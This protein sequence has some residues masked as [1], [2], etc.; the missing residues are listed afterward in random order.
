[1]LAEL[2]DRAA[3]T[4]T[5]VLDAPPGTGKTTRVPLALAGAPWAGGGRIVVLEPRRVAARAAA[6]HMAA[7]LGERPGATVG[8]ITRDDRRAGRSTRVLVVTEG[9]F[10]R[11]VQDDPGLDGVAAVV[12]DEW[13]ERSIHADL[14][15]ALAREVQ[16]ALRPDLRLVVMSATLDGDAARR[17]LGADHASLA[18]AAER[19][20][21]TVAWRARPEPRRFADAVA[22]AVVDGLA[23]QPGD[24]LVFLPGVAEIAA[25]QRALTARRLAAG[26]VVLPLHGRLNAAEQDRALQPAA[27]RRRVVLA[28]D[29]AETSVTVDGVRLVVDG[30]RRRVARF[31]PGRRMD[32]LF[33]VSVSRS[34]AEQR[35]GRAGRQGA[36]HCIRLWPES[37]HHLL[38]DHERPE[39]L[40]ADLCPLAFELA[41]WGAADPS[42]FGWADE[43][44]APAWADAVRTLV[45]LGLA[46]GRPDRLQLTEAGRRAAALGLHPRLARMVDEGRARGLG[47]TAAALAAVLDEGDPAVDARSDADLRSR[48]VA[49]A[50]AGT[51]SADRG[52]ASH[53]RGP[54]AKRDRGADGAAAERFDPGR[55]ARVRAAA[56][57][58]RRRAGIG[59]GEVE[60]ER[61]GYL[62]ALAQPEGI[63]RRREDSAG[64]SPT[65]TGARA[66]GPAGGARPPGVRAGPVSAGAGAAGGA[67]YVQAG[68]GGAEVGDPELATHRWLA[69]AETDGDPTQARVRLAAPILAADLAELTAGAEEVAVVA[70]D[71]R[72]GELET[73]SVRQLGQ[74]VLHR[75]PLDRP[76]PELVGAALADGIAR[77]GLDVLHWTDGARS[78]T[79]RVRFLQARQPDVWPDWSAEALAAT[80]GEWLSGHLGRW[81]PGDGVRRIDV[82]SALR[83]H[84]GWELARLADRLAPPTLAV[85]SGRRVPVSYRDPAA[86]ALAVPPQELFGSA[87]TPAVLDGAE[88]VRLELLSP[89][90]RPIQVTSDLAG[91][92]A[93]SWQAVR[94][95]LRGRYPRHDWPEDPL[96]ATPVRRPARRPR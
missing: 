58:I 82:E 47:P 18:V 68:G 36:G 95:E 28:T 66:A 86:A 20:P 60:P 76:D 52:G 61:T 67:R 57:R 87:R 31:D 81:Q 43:P 44:P 7:T 73:T 78:L 19:Y 72:S 34:A 89:A 32:R 84:L 12:F 77:R 51:A 92:W 35:R 33:T 4:T 41:R 50:S 38:D 62:V 74:I 53:R 65:P 88:P 22:D 79:E 93:G 13:H 45:E 17:A 42:G 54:L 64:R 1:M 83:A 15:L 94:R 96:A 75:A 80:A 91:F 90:G 71:D 48:V 16:S 6:R 55:L 9:V 21:V 24:A 5:L 49:A 37:E 59:D 8:W 46:E 30:G 3:A 69:V 25:V 10:T 40:T 70:W 11:M 26:T 27:G 63:A 56:A 85:P 39:I 14:G 2:V 29:L 23:A